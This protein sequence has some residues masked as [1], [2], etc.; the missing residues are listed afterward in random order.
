MT[1]QV[2]DPG[3][4]AVANMNILKAAVII[5]EGMCATVGHTKEVGTSQMITIKNCAITTSV[6]NERGKKNKDDR[7][8]RGADATGIEKTETTV[9]MNDFILRIKNAGVKKEVARARTR[10]RV[11]GKT[12]GPGISPT[13]TTERD[14]V[15][16]KTTTERR[17]PINRQVVTSSRTRNVSR[18]KRKRKESLV[19]QLLKVRLALRAKKLSVMARKLTR[20][21]SLTGKSQG[22]EEAVRLRLHRRVKRRKPWNVFGMSGDLKVMAPKMK[23]S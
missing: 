5:R 2:I 1:C 22:K 14:L 3:T 15:T 18:E 20:E 17:C 19:H 6:G 7:D 21:K 9:E 12:L 13:S 10:N 16:A 4:E 11:T 8:T 23:E